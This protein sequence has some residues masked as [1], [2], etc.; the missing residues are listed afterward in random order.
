MLLVYRRIEL[1][2]H[3]RS[4]RAFITGDGKCIH[5]MLLVLKNLTVCGLILV[6]NII[7]EAFNFFQNIFAVE[8]E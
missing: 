7:Q 5:E 8:N 6:K 3:D 1:I 4:C 2:V